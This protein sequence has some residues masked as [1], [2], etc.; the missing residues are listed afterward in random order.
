MDPAKRDFEPVKYIHTSYAMNQEN[1]D[2]IR[3][4]PQDKD[5]DDHSNQ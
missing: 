4:K 1:M 2:V 3:L 5:Y